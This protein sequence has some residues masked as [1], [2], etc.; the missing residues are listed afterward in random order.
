MSPT[1]PTVTQNGDGTFTF[2]SASTGTF[3]FNYT[4]TGKQSDLTA[5]DAGT[6]DNLGDS[7]AIDGDTLVVGRLRAHIRPGAAY[8]FVNSGSGWG[9]QQELTASDGVPATSSAARWGSVATHRR[10]RARRTR[11]GP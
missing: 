11:W 9:F 4:A 1:G 3:S 10:R 8:V 5:S 6:G 2:T 7:V